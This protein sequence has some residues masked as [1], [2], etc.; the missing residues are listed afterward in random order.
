MWGSDGAKYE[1]D[2]QKNE[3][4]GGNRTIR[5]F[6]C[7]DINPELDSDQRPRNP[8]ILRGGSDGRSQLGAIRQKYQ[9]PQKGRIVNHGRVGILK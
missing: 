8:Q 5:D 2:Y 9:F 4:A 1:G 6:N 7:L 3:F